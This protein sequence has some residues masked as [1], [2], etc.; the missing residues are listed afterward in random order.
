MNEYIGLILF[1][2]FALLLLLKVPVS[3]SLGLSSLLCLIILDVPLVVVGQRIFTALDSFSIMAIPFFILSGNLMIEGGLSKRIVNFAMSLLAR[4]RGGLAMASILA[5]AIFGALSGSG[6]ATVIS[7]GGMIYPEMIRRGY[8]DDTMAGLIATSGA[9]GPIIPP[10]IVMVFFGTVTG[11]SITKMFAGG[12]GAGLLM[13][14]MLF[15]VTYFKAV[16]EKWPKLEKNEEKPKV[17][18]SFKDSFWALLM[19]VIILG[20]I[21]GGFFTP[22]EA[23]AVSI[24]YALFVGLFIYKEL[25]LSN[26]IRIIKDSAVSATIVLFI[27]AASSAF[28]WLFTYANIAAQVNNFVCSLNVGPTLFLVLVCVVMLIF[29]TFMDATATIVLLMPMM[30]PLSQT[31]GIDP[32]H[33]GVVVCFALTLGGLTPPV[34]VN[35]FSMASVSKLPM[36]RIARGEL[37]F[38]LTALACLII[39]LFVPQIVMFFPNLLG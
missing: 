35:I 26:I 20:G 15:A 30:Y 3:F 10:S 21:Y 25:K 8:K 11:V 19:P 12:I 24:F 13:A 33:F 32:I 37:P 29:G 28:A 17:W 6:P 31:L 22:T 39:L 7:I 16:R 23:A 14:I 1:G 4:V 5:C 18:T 9:L 2:S 27:I 38:A 34:A 36:G